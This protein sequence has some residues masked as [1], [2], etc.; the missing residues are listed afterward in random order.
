MKAE[1]IAFYKPLLAKK[2]AREVALEGSEEHHVSEMVFKELEK[3]PKGQDQWAAKLSVFKELLE[4]HIKEEEGTIFKAAEKV[5]S[6]NK[7]QSILKQFVE[8]KQNLKA[9]LQ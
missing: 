7:F 9:N 3:M 1:E 6:E 8:E 5:L 4:H 2:E